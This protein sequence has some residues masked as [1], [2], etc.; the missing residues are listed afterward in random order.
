MEAKSI[1]HSK[2]EVVQ[3]VG[4]VVDVQFPADAVPDIF[5]AL[6]I[7][8]PQGALV[9]EVQ[10]HLG[11]NRVRTV[12]MDATDGL[13]RGAEVYDTGQPI[14]MPVGRNVRGRLLNVVGNAIDG[15]PQPEAEGFMPIHTAPPAF[16]ELSTSVEMLETGIKVVD[17]LEPY[18]RGGKI[19]LFGGAGVG[20]TVL[21]ME[22]INN[23]AKAHE[24]LSVFAG[25]GERTR[26]GNDLLREMLESGV[27]NYG[28]E[29]M[30]S[31]EE[32][33]W[34]LSKVDMDAVKQSNISLVFGQMNEPPGARARVALSGL[35]IAEYFRDL[36][37][38]DVLLFIDNI[39]RFTQ[40]GSEVSALLGRMPSAV[41]YQPTLA[42]E[43]GE[44][45]ERITSTKTGSI[46][47]VQAIYVPADD[48]TDPAPATTFA[49][50]DATT[51][52]SRQIASLGIYPAID[53]LDSTSRILDPRVLGQ[54]HYNTAQTVKELLQRY[55]ELQDIIA[56]LGM[57]ELSDE[58]KLAVHRARRAQRYMSQPF[59]VAEQFTNYSGK[60]VKIADTIRGFKMI[61]GGEL[62]H[63]PEGAFTYVGPIEEAIEKGEKLMAEA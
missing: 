50:L 2:G 11:E 55:K 61:L 45:Q 26:E 21:I 7:D 1:E 54:D 20:K 42:T 44:L 9:L 17:L 53:P 37:G 56:I 36:G 15:L 47:S 30:R 25:V 34:D 6:K 52:L 33:G 39:F 60:Y 18:P 35:T 4:P 57:D 58:D 8:R 3:I 13:T 5:R 19:G 43:M 23:I 46:T 40:A 29:F 28:K 22:L 24:G 41:G 31:M 59:F 51:V 32:G 49:H 62:D 38:R 10:Q 16:A 63:L 14:T 27:V 12:A 48:L